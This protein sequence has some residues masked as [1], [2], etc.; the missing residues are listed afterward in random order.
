MIRPLLVLAVVTAPLWGQFSGLATPYDGSAVYF[1]S[2]L[3]LKG[4]GQPDYGKLFVADETGVKLFRGLER[5]L[6]PA[7]GDCVV[8]SQYSLDGAEVTSDGL[9]VAAPGSVA[10]SGP[11]RGLL[12]ATAVITAGGV[13]EVPGY[14]YL[15]PS[16]RYAISNITPNVFSSASLVFVDP[17]TGQQTPITLPGVS[18]PWPA[19][20]PSNGRAISNDGT[21]IFSYANNAYL[22]RPGRDVQAFPVPGANALAIDAAG[23]LVLYS[24]SSDLRSRNLTTQQ[25]ALVAAGQSDASGLSDDGTRALFLRGGQAWIVQTDGTGLRQLTRDTAGIRTATLSGNGNV[26]YAETNVGALLK[27]DVASGAQVELVGR[28]PYVT[29]G[30]AADAGLAASLSGSGIADSSSQATPPVGM[31]LG[32]VSVEVAGQSV[33]V[34]QLSPTSVGFFVPWNIPASGTQPVI[35]QASGVDTPF[36]FPTSTILITTGPRAGT[37]WHQ[38]WSGMVSNGSPAH[39]GEL[40]HVFAV[41]LGPVSPEVPPGTLAPSTEPLARLTMPMTCSDSTILYAGLQ[42]GAL[43]R[44]YQV[45]MRLGSATGY[46]RFACSNDPIFLTLYVVS[47]RQGGRGTA[48]PPSRPPRR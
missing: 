17:Q 10:Y 29:S 40:I 9:T 25:D 7:M 19:Y 38:D 26:V 39:T 24:I 11:C 18:G 42:P 3:S 23:D 8:G 31:S 15:S 41:G 45:D 5:I 34:L 46:L 4:A 27:I 21:S 35:I 13:T 47:P 1:S 44:I 36:D 32:G 28:T 16:G 30:A 48:V 43:E 2:T 37:V 14:A 6:P 20:F 33:P 12:K 22:A